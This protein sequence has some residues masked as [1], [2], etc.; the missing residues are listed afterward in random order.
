[1]KL[2]SNILLFIGVIFFVIGLVILVVGEANVA[3][4]YVVGSIMLN[5]CGLVLKKHIK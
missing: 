4:F 3:R 1:M 2:L 5:T